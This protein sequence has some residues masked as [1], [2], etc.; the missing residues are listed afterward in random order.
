[1]QPKILVCRLHERIRIENRVDCQW[2]RSPLCCLFAATTASFELIIIC[3]STRNRRSLRDD[4]VELCHCLK[5]H[6]VSEEVRVTASMDR[7]HRDM[8]RRMADAGLDFVHIQGENGSVDPGFIFNR[9]T[10]ADGSMRIDRILGQLCPFL[11][12]R[13]VDD[14]NELISCGAYRNR[15]VL[16]GGRLHHVCETAGHAYCEYFL[17]P[18]DRE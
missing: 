1:M 5:S 15:M 9:L 16:G 18:R 2:V 8:I 4:I 3:F 13:P 12:Y 17:N 14:G 7:P 10:H 6:P 11:T